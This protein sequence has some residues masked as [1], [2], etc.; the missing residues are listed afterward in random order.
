MNPNLGSQPETPSDSAGS[1]LSG[2]T[3]DPRRLRPL[4]PPD[5]RAWFPVLILCQAVPMALRPTRWLLGTLMAG[6]GSL[7]MA[8]LL[9][10]Q[11]DASSPW[12]WQPQSLAIP[13]AGRLFSGVNGLAVA[14]WPFTPEPW[15]LMLIWAAWF[16][17]AGLL[18]VPVARSAAGL[19]C[20]G[21]AVPMAWAL[22]DLP[23]RGA[24][25]MVASLIPLVLVAALGFALWLYRLL[26]LSVEG[27]DILGAVLFGLAWAV[28]LIAAV[29]LLGLYLGAG[30]M[31]GAVAVDGADPFDA[32]SRAFQY[33]LFH[34]V[35]VLVYQG[36][37]ALI[38]IALAW[39]GHLVTSTAHTFIEETMRLHTELSSPADDIM[40]VWRWFPAYLLSGLLLSFYACA[41]VLIYQ[42]FR[43]LSD[44]TAEVAWD[45][46]QAWL[47]Q[48]GESP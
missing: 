31:L 39:G 28:G 12:L 25:F 42:R 11:G 24:S 2:L 4:P 18:L 40:N 19:A 17:A 35:R 47:H 15:A 9:A 29:L 36:G 1:F 10:W 13:S 34:P 22:R 8:G 21:R 26:L 20:H 33:T 46:P 43:R 6:L 48:D 14:P 27:L 16:I 37:A 3:S 44:G 45:A 7:L 30:L 41:Q 32:L 38:T 5:W 23:K